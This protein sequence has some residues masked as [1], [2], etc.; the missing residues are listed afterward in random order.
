MSNGA[1]TV[2]QARSANFRADP[3]QPTRM[4]TVAQGTRVSIA[5][6]VVPFMA[7]LPA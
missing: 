3:Q 5:L 1:A 2:R 4:A 6:D 7:M